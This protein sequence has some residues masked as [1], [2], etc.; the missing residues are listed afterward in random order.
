MNQKIFAVI[1]ASILL[2]SSFGVPIFT[3]E[4]EKS[5]GVL[6]IAHGS[7]SEGW[8]KTCSRSG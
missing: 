7:P 5:I 2:L 8:C 3:A 6:V 4:E 1:L